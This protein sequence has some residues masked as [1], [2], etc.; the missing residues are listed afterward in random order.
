MKGYGHYLKSRRPEIRLIQCL[1]IS[2]KGLKDDFFIFSGQWHDGLPCLVKEGTLGEGSTAKF[3]VLTLCN[4]FISPCSLL[5]LKCTSLSFNGFADNKSTTLLFRLVNRASL[6]RILQSE[7]YVNKADGQLRAA[8]LIL[9]YTLISRAFHAPKCVI[10]AK[11]PRLHHISVAYEGFVVPEGIP[12]PK[13]TPSTQSLHVATLSAEV[14]SPSPILQEKE[15]GEEGQEE[16]GFVELTESVDEFEVFNHPSSPKSPPEEMGIQRKPQKSLL[17]L[18]ENQLGKWGPEKSAQPK[19][20][21]PP[22][23]SPPR[24]PQPTLPSRIEQAD[25]KRRR[26]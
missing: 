24:A 23:K 18:I 17:E 2:N 12:L 21:P 16:Q 11:D 7:V 13:S 4:S 5:L 6:D 9:G 15:E 1:P 19:L 8:H 26:E 10:K 22:P 25:P 3:Y 14:S 20:P